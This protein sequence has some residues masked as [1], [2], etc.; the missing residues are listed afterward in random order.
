MAVA[1]YGLIPDLACDWNNLG[2]GARHLQQRADETRRGALQ[3]PQ[4][5]PSSPR[6]SLARLLASQRTTVVLRPIHHHFSHH[7]RDS[8]LSR[9]HRYPCHS[10]LAPTGNGT[11]RP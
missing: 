7:S 5:F 11:N 1:V 4:P 10:S 8:R 9:N 3:K 2:P 6:F